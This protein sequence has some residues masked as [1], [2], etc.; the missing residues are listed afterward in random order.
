MCPGFEGK[1]AVH[2]MTVLR[3]CHSR[4][5]AMGAVSAMGYSME[6][7]DNM[8]FCPLPSTLDIAANSSSQRPMLAA[9][10]DPFCVELSSP[11]QARRRWRLASGC[12]TETASHQSATLSHPATCTS[13][14]SAPLTQG[15]P[16]YRSRAQRLQDR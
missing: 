2:R 8:L 15:E 10:A 7:M 16:G 4:L 3:L 6:N 5:S 9:H 13:T 1:L 12:W 11:S 14:C